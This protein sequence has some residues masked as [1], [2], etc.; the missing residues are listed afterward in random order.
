MNAIDEV[1]RDVE[2]K[3]PGVRIKL[4]LPEKSLLGKITEGLQT[5]MSWI[6]WTRGVPTAFKQLF[7]T[8][9]PLMGDAYV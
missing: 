1:F 2:M 6:P 8:S 4:S 7:Y 3:M 9:E 5:G